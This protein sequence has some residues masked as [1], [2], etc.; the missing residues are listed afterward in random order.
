MTLREQLAGSDRPLFGMWLNSGAP[1]VAEIC[2]G[3]GLDWVLVDAEHGPNDVPSVL[4]QLQAIAAYPV[5]ALVRPPVGDTA[6]IKQY[7]DIGAQNLLIPMVDSAEQ[8]AEL[9]RAVRYPPRGVRGVGSSLARAARWNRVDDYLATADEHVSL[10]VQIESAT[11]VEN[12]ESIVAVEGVDG[13]LL[14]PADLA[15]SMGVLGQQA[16]PDVVAA[17][18]RCL[19]VARAA[20]KGAGVNAFVPEAAD[21]Y[22][23][24]GANLVCVGADVTLL[25]RGSEAL[26]ARFLGT[27][28]A[29]RAGY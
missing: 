20:G 18:E 13:I 5:A 4:A 2:A 15:A 23:A 21:R 25:A 7:L 8:A 24:A 3:S 6:L 28:P 26:A 17:V 9:V 1:L 11:A 22:V 14:G 10:T 12:V 27:D 19:A 29:K 16:H